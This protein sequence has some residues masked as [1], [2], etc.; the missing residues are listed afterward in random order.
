MSIPFLLTSSSLSNTN[1]VE[2]HPLPGLS[3]DKM[4]L[5]ES[6]CMQEPPGIKDSDDDIEG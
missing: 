5:S 1:I 2:I 4:N 6:L 3:I